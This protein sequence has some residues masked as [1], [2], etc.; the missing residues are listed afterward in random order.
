MESLLRALRGGPGSLLLWKNYSVPSDQDQS[1]FGHVRAMFCDPAKA[2]SLLRVSI[3]ISEKS[4]LF[5]GINGM[6]RVTH[7]SPALADTATCV[8]PSLLLLTHLT[9]VLPAFS[10]LNHTPSLYL[11]LPRMARPE[12][13][14]WEPSLPILSAW[15]S[16][17]PHVLSHWAH[18]H[19]WSHQHSL[20]QDTLAQKQ[21][22]TAAQY[23]YS[24]APQPPC[25]H[26]HTQCL[27]S[28]SASWQP[29]C[30]LGGV[31]PL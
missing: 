22:K 18:G 13:T 8:H 17:K 16:S 20:G 25:Q 5:W 23:R 24:K 26:T 10:H 6:I 7:L 31:L 21:V 9:P 19:V 3:L 11:Q 14:Q 15:K 28:G 12:L 1:W 4:E 2:A 27:T 30:S 29:E